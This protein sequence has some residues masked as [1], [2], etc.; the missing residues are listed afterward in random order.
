MI[1]EG[2]FQSKLFCDSNCSRNLLSDIF[3]ENEEV[4]SLV[5]LR[6]IQVADFGHLKSPLYLIFKTSHGLTFLKQHQFQLGV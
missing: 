4:P 3:T 6:I 1:S 2:P 5:G